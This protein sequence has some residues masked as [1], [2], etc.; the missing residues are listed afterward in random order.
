MNFEFPRLDVTLENLVG[1][2]NF[3][4]VWGAQAEGIRAFSPKDDSE[5]VLRSK[6]A[7]I[8]AR[9]HNG[10]DFW[11]KYFRK[12]YYPAQYSDEGVVA[13]KCLKP[14]APQEHYTLL[15]EELKLMIH[16]GTHKNIVNLLGACTQKGPLLVILEYCPH[17]DLRKYLRSKTLCAT[18]IRSE[19]TTKDQLSWMDLMRMSMEIAEGNLKQEI[20]AT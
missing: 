15:A 10:N 19:M 20:K 18:W 1:E 6:L 4:E 16:L 2:G 5:L 13:V 17:G 11:V 8:Y 14:G 12:E 7:N 9:E 3:G